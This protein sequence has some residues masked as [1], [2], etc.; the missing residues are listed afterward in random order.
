MGAPSHPEGEGTTALMVTGTPDWRTMPVWGSR[1]TVGLVSAATLGATQP[2]VTETAPSAQVVVDVGDGVDA[3][4]ARSSP[5]R[6][7][8]GEPRGTARR[9]G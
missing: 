7:A 3:N 5:G 8:V 9:P 4:R 6:L 2:C 1:S